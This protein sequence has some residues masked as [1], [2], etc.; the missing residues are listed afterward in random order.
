MSNIHSLNTVLRSADSTE[1]LVAEYRKICPL[2]LE[3]SKAG[4]TERDALNYCSGAAEFVMGYLTGSGRLYLQAQSSSM[5]KDLNSSTADAILKKFAGQGSLRIGYLIDG[6]NLGHECVFAGSGSQWAF[7]QA[8]ANGSQ[9]ER[10]TLAPK[11]NPMNKNWCINNMSE[12]QFAEFFVGLTNSGYSA[13]LFRVPMNK[14][15]I[16]GFSTSGQNLLA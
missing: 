9:G 4:E 8:N 16:G 5:R 1:K 15:S 2:V 12:A 10:F 14:W 13:R 11:L 3:P 6:G 7:Y